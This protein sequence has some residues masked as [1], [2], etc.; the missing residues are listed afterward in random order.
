M[1]ITVRNE[2]LVQVITCGSLEESLK[3]TLD[4]FGVSGYTYFNVKGNGDSGYQDAVID[5]DTNILVMIMVPEDKAEPLMEALYEKY[6]RKGH[7]LMVFSLEAQML[8]S[9]KA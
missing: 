5:G 7:H 6:L 9:K 3:G 8:S 4:K 2:K 1:S